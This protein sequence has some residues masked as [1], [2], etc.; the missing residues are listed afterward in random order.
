MVNPIDNNTP[1]SVTL[2]AEEWNVALS[3]LREAPYKHVAQL[4]EQI[5]SQC[6]Q[7]RMDGAG[8]DIGQRMDGAA[9]SH[10]N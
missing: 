9:A 10:A 2:T 1:C 6:M 3:V 4:I 8:R 7:A 5:I